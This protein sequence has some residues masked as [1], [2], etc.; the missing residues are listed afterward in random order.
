MFSDVGG[1]NE[2]NTMEIEMDKQ[3]ETRRAIEYEAV[4]VPAHLSDVLTTNPGYAKSSV[5]NNPA[6]NVAVI[7]NQD[8]R[9]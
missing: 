7:N 2:C 9:Q 6:Y 4:S 1:E 5:G 8:D 3:E